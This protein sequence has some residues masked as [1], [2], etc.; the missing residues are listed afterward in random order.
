M[1]SYS[2]RRIREINT[3]PRQ[4]DGPPNHWIVRLRNILGAHNLQFWSWDRISVGVRDR[5][6]E[7][8]GVKI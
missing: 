5:F 1:G 8:T 7:T 3:E 2:L 6:R 4:P